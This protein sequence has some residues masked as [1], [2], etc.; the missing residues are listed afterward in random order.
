MSW[1]P[2][3]DPDDVTALLACCADLVDQLTLSSEY[4]VTPA[5]YLHPNSTTAR[6]VMVTQNRHIV[7]CYGRDRPN[8]LRLLL[9]RGEGVVSLSGPAH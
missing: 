5:R 9:V 1:V 4:I 7:Q 2:D 3:R 8:H 6:H